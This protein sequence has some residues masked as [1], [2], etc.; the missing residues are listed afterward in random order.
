MDWKP[1]LAYITGAMDQELLLRHEYLS[2]E[3]RFLPQ[4][5]TGGGS[6]CNRLLYYRG[7][8]L[9]WLSDRDGK[10]CPAFQQLIDD[11]S[12]RRVPLPPQSPH[13]N[14]YAERWV[15]SAASASARHDRRPDRT[16]SGEHSA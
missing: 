8:D 14:A 16:F 6:G 9:V 11:A 1:L 2:P 13:L 7:V 5:I 4:Q 3:N 15:R 12:V 10:Y